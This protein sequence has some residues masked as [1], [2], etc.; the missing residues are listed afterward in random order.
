MRE[1]VE[2][3]FDEEVYDLLTE[4]KS[5]MEIKNPRIKHIEENSENNMDLL[6]KIEKLSHFVQTG[7]IQNDSIFRNDHDSF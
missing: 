7:S 3:N 2:K 1:Y 6:K 4:F 5:K